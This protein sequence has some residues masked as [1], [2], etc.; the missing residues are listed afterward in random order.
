M[1][2]GGRFRLSDRQPV[3]PFIKD[4][5]QS[6]AIESQ[7]EPVLLRKFRQLCFPIF[8]LSRADLFQ[9]LFVKSA[10]L[11]LVKSTVLRRAVHPEFNLFREH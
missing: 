11:V 7:T 6:L 4:G 3:R 8:I 9:V 2:R 5:A 10:M 1:H